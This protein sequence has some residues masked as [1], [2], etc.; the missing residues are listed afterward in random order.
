M[1]DNNSSRLI[2]LSDCTPV[3]SILGSP[4][5]IG[6]FTGT[7][8]KGSIKLDWKPPANSNEIPIESYIIRYGKSNDPPD[9]INGYV[10]TGMTTI[11]ITKLLNGVSYRFW[12][13][14]VNRYGEGV[15]SAPQSFTP[16]AP[17]DAIIL[18]RR[19]E[20]D[21][22]ENIDNTRPQYV[23]FEFVP[24]LN[25]NGYQPTQYII[26]YYQIDSNGQQ[27][28]NSNLY[29]ETFLVNSSDNELMV[30]TSAKPIYNTNGFMGNYIRREFRIDEHLTDGTYRFSVYSKNV[31]GLS[32]VSLQ[33]VDITLGEHIPH[34]IPP[35]WTNINTDI[36]DITGIIPGDKKVTLQFR[37]T[38]ISGVGVGSKYRIQY[39]TNPNYWYYPHNQ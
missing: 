5:K 4:G 29:E 8:L 25:A 7:S 34:F 10:S 1:S 11:T 24:P 17:P 16:S 27:M 36:G 3:Y 15:L 26:K 28:P 20:H 14:G 37:Q 12:I 38:D 33:S 21:T 23:G 9:M 32:A 13:S 22:V 31:S 39:T 35:K 6:P 19:A 18:F 2:F 30:D